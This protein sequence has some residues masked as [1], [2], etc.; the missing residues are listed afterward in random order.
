[1]KPSGIQWEKDFYAI[2]EDVHCSCS[3][4]DFGGRT[5]MIERLKKAFGGI[6]GSENPIVST[7]SGK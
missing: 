4:F 7:K 3:Q 5:K 6:L 1:L 2:F